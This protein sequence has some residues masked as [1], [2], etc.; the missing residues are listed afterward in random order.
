MGET[1]TDMVDRVSVDQLDVYQ[2]VARYRQLMVV[3]EPGSGKS[4]LLEHLMLAYAEE[5]L[6]ILVDKP[7]V[8]LVK[9]RSLNNDSEL[10]REKLIQNIVDAF[11]PPDS[12][13]FLRANLFVK[14]SL[15]QGK[16]ML[17]F[18]GLDEVNSS[19]REQVV[20]CLQDLLERHSGCRAVI[21]C[22]TAVYSGEFSQHVNQTLKA[23]NFEDHQ[24]RQFLQA[25]KSQMSED[26]SIE[27]LMQTLR[28]QPRIMELARNPLMLTI[29][30]Y[31]YADTSFVLSH[32]RAEFYQRSTNILLEKWDQ[33]KLISNQYKGREKKLVLQKLALHNQKTAGQRQSESC[34]VKYS[35]ALEQI[36]SVLPALNREAKDAV[37]MLDEIVERSG[38]LLAVEGG[39]R[40]EFV[41]PTLQEFFAAAALREQGEDLIK[42]F[43]ADSNLWRETIK[44]WCG[45]ASNSREVIHS[46][47]MLEPLL[48]FECL[49]DVSE[50]EEDQL[51]DQILKEF[52][53]KLGKDK[54]KAAINKAFGI[55]AASK[56]PRGK[57]VFRFLTNALKQ[58]Q[59][60]R[61]YAAASALSKTNRP[62]AAAVL[63]K[64]CKVNSS[65]RSIL[66]LLTQMGDLAVDELRNL[67]Q[68]G[69]EGAIAALGQVGTPNAA[70]ELASFLFGNNQE[71]AT[72]SAAELA[73]LL[74]KA[75]ITESLQTYSVDGKYQLRGEWSWIWQPFEADRDLT[76]TVN[77]IIGQLAD[78]SQS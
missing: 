63:A 9:L 8:V 44:M 16:L 20:R 56:N 25:W 71:T 15:K 49:A 43:K 37:P 51:Y 62:E 42:Y 36:Q 34:S 64:H 70:I 77:A 32:S 50:P 59:V 19:A 45:L 68:Q 40:Y 18:D 57:S 13:N 55:I 38:L 58:D 47:Y 30:A 39:E 65:P 78:D 76:A 27:Q 66:Q 60:S 2:A 72:R 61:Q 24:I 29:I 3:G 6:E 69:V 5:R 41:H 17:L 52:K 75:D 21:T 48:A 22:R 73:C 46:I 11:N 54:D 28:D 31:L 23:V 1:D 4:V 74:S 12:G 53:E 14:Q 35:E 67:A 7:T 26:K 33:G 10:T